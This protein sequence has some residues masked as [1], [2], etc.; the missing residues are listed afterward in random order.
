MSEFKIAMGNGAPELDLKK[1]F[2]S[3]EINIVDDECG[4]KIEIAAPFATWLQ[5]LWVAGMRRD[6]SSLILS[7]HRVSTIMLLQT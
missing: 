6:A 3:G 1:L 4:E 7:P 2:S 5:K